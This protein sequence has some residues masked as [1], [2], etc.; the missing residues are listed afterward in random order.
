MPEPFL[1][2]G[3]KKSS[4]VE[5]RQIQSCQIKKKQ[6]KNLCKETSIRIRTKMGPKVR[7]DGNATEI[8]VYH[9]LFN[10][11]L[12]DKLINRGH[13]HPLLSQ[14]SLSNDSK[15]NTIGLN[16]K[17]PHYIALY[18]ISTKMLVLSVF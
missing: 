5:P 1:C 10:L 4:S 7:N 15:A 16:A 13:R 12:S 2:S 3:A 9:Y 17:S 14:Q 11:K 8:H 18:V 6:R